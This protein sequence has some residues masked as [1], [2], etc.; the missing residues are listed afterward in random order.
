MEK[1]ISPSLPYMNHKNYLS[2]FLDIHQQIKRGNPILYYTALGHF[3]LFILFILL[4]LIDSRTVQGINTWN[5][6]IK[7]AIS[8]AV[9]T[10]T[11]GYFLNKLKYIR[12]KTIFSLVI[13]LCMWVEMLLISFQAARGVPS[14]FNNTN[15][16]D[17][18][19][20]SIMGI[21]IL[22][23]S[24]VIIIVFLLFLRSHT[25]IPRPILSA[26]RWG[27]AVFILANMAGGYMVRIYSHSAGID[28]GTQRVPFF[29]WTESDVRIAHFLGMH[30]VQLLPVAA[31]WL[32]NKWNHQSSLNAVRVM[33]FIY[34]TAVVFTFLKAVYYVG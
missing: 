3:I 14:H 12:L 31:Y 7:F 9:F 18:A 27:M 24:V 17:L 6:P 19:I 21:A 4:S 33:G 11:Y 26:M 15:P 10:F 23:N 29:N 32:Q 25:H 34:M 30:A 5:K 22:I 13:S 28:T 1:S 16:F 8:I 2:I 20:F